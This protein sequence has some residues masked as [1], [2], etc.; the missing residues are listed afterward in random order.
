MDN[1][2]S[3]SQQIDEEQELDQSPSEATTQEEENLE[4]AE[5]PEE[6]EVEPE[7]GEIPEEPAPREPSRRENLRIQQLLSKLHNQPNANYEQPQAPVDY[8]QM[9]D[10]DPETL[11]ALQ[12]TTSQYGKQQYQA[13]LGQAD[14]RT[15]YS[16]FRTFLEIDAPRVEAKYKFLDKND[17]ANFRPHIANA[18]NEFYLSMVGHDAGSR[19]VNDSGIRYNEFTDAIVELANEIATTKVT[20]STRNI[21]RQASQTGIRPDGSTTKRLNLNKAPEAMSDEELRAY[22]KANSASSML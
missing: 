8:S 17:T 2:E 21:A 22:I 9:I 15:K 13:G 12:Q 16:E 5:Q 11:A 10:A 14:E 20:S 19:K 6:A 3:N 18:V 4:D 7:E 1:D